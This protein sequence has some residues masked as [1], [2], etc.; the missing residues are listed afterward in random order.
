MQKVALWMALWFCASLASAQ[1]II[2]KVVSIRVDD[3]LTLLTADRQQNKVRRAEMD[4][5]EKA[6][7]Y[8]QKSKQ[9]LAPMVFGGG[10]LLGAIKT[11]EGVLV[12][13]D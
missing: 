4:T 12:T 5:P 11:S 3:T 2:G 1:E 7:P 9:A 8:G 13:N 6:H 10:V